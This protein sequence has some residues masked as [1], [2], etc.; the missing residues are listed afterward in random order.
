MKSFKSIATSSLKQTFCIVMV[1]MASLVAFG[2]QP[3]EG[4]IVYTVNTTS[5][6]LYKMFSD[7]Q[8]TSEEVVY[9]TNDKF[10]L[11]NVATQLINYIDLK[12]DAVYVACPA[13][14]MTQ[15][16][17]V[18]NLIETNEKILN[19]GGYLRKLA[20]WKKTEA[21]EGLVDGY[22]AIKYSIDTSFT[23]EG[24][25]YKVTSFAFDV[26]L[27]DFLSPELL[28]PYSYFYGMPYYEHTSEI[29]QDCPAP[30]LKSVRYQTRV[31]KSMERMTPDASVFTVPSNV[32][33]VSQRDF[34]KAYNKYMKGLNKT[35]EKE[36]TSVEYTAP[37]DIWDF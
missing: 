21:L 4:K 6:G 14:Q 29:K 24:A 35:R 33:V 36:G 19:N 37:E 12:E 11:F 13:I 22:P 18:T 3:F 16:N 15:K 17:T 30:L 8:G 7:I 31:V 20:Q 2:Q 34:E 1:F 25:N 9:I 28:K 27:K 26:C 5:R 23:P 32:K 10:I